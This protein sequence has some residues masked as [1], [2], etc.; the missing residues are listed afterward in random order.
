[1][2]LCAGMQSGG[3]TLLS[4]CFLQR[5]DTDGE[6]DMANDC[7]RLAFD[8][9]SA[10]IVWCKMTVGAFR[11]LDVAEVY[12]DLGWRPEPVLVVRDVRA[13]L[14]SLMRKPYGHGGKT[15][16]RPPL[17]V[18]LRRFLRDWELFRS[19]GWPIIKF[20]RFVSDPRAVLQEAC[21]ALGLTWDE[22][23]L[24]WPRDL[25]DIAYPSPLANTT[26]V[27]SIG[28]GG[29]EE[30]ILASDEQIDIS[31]VPPAELEWLEETFLAYNEVHQYPLRLPRGPALNYSHRPGP[32]AVALHERMLEAE[33]KWEASRE[34]AR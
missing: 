13:V 12:S 20:E 30:S 19:H 10:P 17:R 8:R 22:G 16:D 27:T 25:A 31:A 33:R 7:I 24:S 15:G 14:A 21:L 26:F 1:M 6:L 23:M 34:S 9:A 5:R 29:L 28:N 3:T 2:I 32:R 11:W 4:W 18:R